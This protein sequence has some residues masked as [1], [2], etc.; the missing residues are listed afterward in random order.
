MGLGDGVGKRGAVILGA[1]SGNGRGRRTCYLHSL[2]SKPRKI[3]E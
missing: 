1:V 3:G 2:E